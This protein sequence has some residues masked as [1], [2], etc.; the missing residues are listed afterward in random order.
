MMATVTLV[1]LADAGASTDWTGE[2]EERLMPGLY[3]DRVR[4]GDCVTWDPGLIDHR[5][6]EV[7]VVPCED[8]HLVEII[9]VLDPV[10]APV[11]LSVMPD[12]RARVMTGMCEPL[13]DEA[14]GGVWD[15]YGLFGA[16]WVTPGFRT[17][18]D[19]SGRGWCGVSKMGEEPFAGR[20]SEQVQYEV[21]PVGSCFTVEASEVDCLEPHAFEVA[22][23]A[24]L[25]AFEERERAI[26]AIWDECD[27]S[28]SLQALAVAD[29]AVGTFHFEI[30]ESS[31]A[32]G[33]RIAECL[34]A[35]ITDDG[36]PVDADRW[37]IGG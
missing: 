14:M 18:L 26:E 19:G 31:W 5:P 17:A 2:R 13:M 33:R 23:H 37:L 22:G 28:G 3:W 8:E 16:H 4:S 21:A 12:L 30:E 32:A 25:T 1:G 27:A 35:N 36:I 20:A 7:E 9:S 15:R 10:P 11:L 24:D 29:P 6:V 34:V